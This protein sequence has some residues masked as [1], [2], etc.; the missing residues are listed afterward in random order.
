MPTVIPEVVK[1][2]T[3]MI[4]ALKNV[5]IIRG[6]I[7]PLAATGDMNQAKAIEELDAERKKKQEERKKLKKKQNKRVIKVS[8]AMDCVEK[9]AYD[10]KVALDFAKAI[11]HV[12]TQKTPVDF[13]DIMFGKISGCMIGKAL[14]QKN[15]R[16]RG[17]YVKSKGPGITDQPFSELVRLR[18]GKL[19]PFIP[20]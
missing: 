7:I 15:S 13:G 9:Y 20:K 12:I 10:G 5:Q 11:L 3:T 1:V 17:K 16:S 8:D 14:P 4:P 6:L 19:H 2:T 18:R